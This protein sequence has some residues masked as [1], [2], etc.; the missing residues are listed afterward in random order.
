MDCLNYTIALVVIAIEVQ[1]RLQL[2]AV[3]RCF[4]RCSTRFD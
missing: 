4:V 3:V 2:H 1:A